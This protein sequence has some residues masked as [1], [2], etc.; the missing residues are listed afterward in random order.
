MLSPLKAF[1]ARLAIGSPSAFHQGKNKYMGVR[2]GRVCQEFALLKTLLISKQHE[3]IT[4]ILPNMASTSKAFTANI[5]FFQSQQLSCTVVYHVMS[6]KQ[7][8]FIP[9]SNNS[10]FTRNENYLK[11]SRHIY[12][13]NIIQLRDEAVLFAVPKELLKFYP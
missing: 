5:R 8:R 13:K 2:R 12:H 4:L 6:G 11:L 1:S 10:Y 3:R 9:Y 7:K